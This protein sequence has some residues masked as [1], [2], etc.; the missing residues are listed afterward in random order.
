M[1]VMESYSGMFTSL[2]AKCQ[3]WQ[4]AAYWEH[5]HCHWHA[6]PQKCDWGWRWSRHQSS[7][8]AQT[9]DTWSRLSSQNSQTG[10][11]YSFSRTLTDLI[12]YLG[13]SDH[14]SLRMARRKGCK[15][16]FG[17]AKSMAYC[18]ETPFPLLSRRQP[19]PRVGRRFPRL[20]MAWPHERVERNRIPPGLCDPS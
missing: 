10:D 16:V 5:R 20:P 17:K 14:Q 2:L 18:I 9:S 8:N 12:D 3:K 4:S 1:S 11:C 6:N 7:E 13:Q 15:G 19:R